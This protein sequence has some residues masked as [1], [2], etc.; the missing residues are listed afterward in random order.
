MDLQF[1]D[2]KLLGWER[3]IPS[4]IKVG[5]HI[6][7]TSNKYRQPERKCQHLVIQKIHDDDIYVNSYMDKK[8]PDW[9]LNPTSPYKQQRYYRRIRPITE[10]TGICVNCKEEKV[11]PPYFMCIY[12]KNNRPIKEN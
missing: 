7:C 8:Y 2:N 10:H 3:I 9:I 11:R 5:Q 12:C 6:R 4:E 1:A